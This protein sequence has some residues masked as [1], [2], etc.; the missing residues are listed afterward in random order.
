MQAALPER[1]EQLVADVT[2]VSVKLPG[3]VVCYPLQ[4]SAVGG[5]ARGYLQR[6][7]LTLVVDD[8]VQLEAKNPL[9]CSNHHRQKVVVDIRQ[10]IIL[11]LNIGWHRRRPRP[12]RGRAG[13]SRRQD[14]GG[15]GAEAAGG[16]A[17]PGA[18]VA[19]SGA[20]PS[21]GRGRCNGSPVLRDATVA[22][23]QQA[24]KR[25]AAAAADLTH[26]RAAPEVSDGR[27]C[28]VQAG[29]HG[30]PQRCCVRRAA[31]YPGVVCPACKVA[32]VL[33][34]TLRASGTTL[35]TSGARLQ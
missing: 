21:G 1:L 10:F 29:A 28:P 23:E 6:H 27:R 31:E 19:G 35:P 8:E 16:F 24:I 17:G 11:I 2:F 14:R 20:G 5:V 32:G 18:R 25:Q 34:W 30:R 9:S 15:A 26:Y 22:R 12:T 13:Q 4:R 7:D 3:Q 33:W